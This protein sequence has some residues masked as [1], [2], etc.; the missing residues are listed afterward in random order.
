MTAHYATYFD[1]HYLSRG[2][3]LIES[4]AR[5]APESSIVVLCLDVE[6]E[7]VLR[8][9]ALPNVRLVPLSELEAR[10]PALVEARSTRSRIEYYFTL[11]AP[12]LL[13]VL[14]GDPGVERLAYVDADHYFFAPPSPLIGALDRSSVV[15]LDHR[16]PPSLADK[17]VF[18]RYNVGLLGFRRDDRALA[19]L[20]W[21]RARCLEWCYDRLEGDRYG[22][23]KY[24]D[25]WPVRF[26]GVQVLE[27]KGIGVAPWNTTNYRIRVRCGR[28]MVDDDPLVAYHF[29][30]FRI[31]APWL[32]DSG[33]RVYG[34]HL[35]RET[36][37]GV[38]V[39]YARALRR[40]ARTIRAVGERA[41][42]ADS[43]R[44]A[45]LG[46]LPGWARPAGQR[47]YVL[48]AAVMRRGLLVVFDSFA[49]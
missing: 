15:I 7:R 38:Y 32:F 30:S 44:R 49:V 24:L 11:T 9:L 33:A 29:S 1:R 20:R 14:V 4:L 3:A 36:R 26:A 18:G 27:Y 23:Q 5:V 43:I 47:A 6:T 46:A 40:A 31:L 45:P 16:Y 25:A 17:Y 2:L 13:D 22:D 8:A 28:V 37:R 35:G 39:P 12:F 41:S 34:V 42:P 19:I 48:G 10:D 21:W